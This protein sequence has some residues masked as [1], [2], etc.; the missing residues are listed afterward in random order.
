MYSD[1]T[2]SSA[3][4]LWYVGAI[5]RLPPNSHGASSC[6]CVCCAGVRVRRVD[7][8]ALHSHRLQP[9]S[10]DPHGIA[11]RPS[12][13]TSRD[14]TRNLYRRTKYFYKEAEAMA[15]RVCSAEGYCVATGGWVCTCSINSQWSTP[16]AGFGA[17][18]SF[19]ESADGARSTKKGGGAEER[20]RRHGRP[21]SWA[22][23]RPCFCSPR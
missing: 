1:Q 11:K 9:K 7:P 18:A 19:R 3:L 8:V 16:Q 4:S 10:E 17:K 13:P 20:W 21:C 14:T 2:A 15:F 12:R 23:K 5:C 22:L 6:I